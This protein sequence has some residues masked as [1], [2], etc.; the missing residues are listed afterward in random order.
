MKATIG[1]PY[2]AKDGIVG[3]PAHGRYVPFDKPQNV[4]AACAI[5]NSSLFYTYS[6]AYGDCFHL[7]DTLVSS[8]PITYKLSMDGKL[9]EI[10]KCLQLSISANAE[11]KTIQTRDESEITY[12]EFFVYKSKSIIDNIDAILA[13]HYGFT[14]EEFNFIINYDIK[15]RMGQDDGNDTE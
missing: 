6:I 12:A 9:I 5:L 1:L 8:F 2:Y 11:L 4:A 15:Y 7:S 10:G 3:V 14:D 13:K